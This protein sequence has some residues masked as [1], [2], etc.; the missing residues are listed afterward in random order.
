[1][2]LIT[3][4]ICPECGARVKRLGSKGMCRRCEVALA[5]Q[6]EKQVLLELEHGEGDADGD[7]RKE[8]A[9]LRRKAER[10]LRGARD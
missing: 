6:V 3:Y 10:T 8:L 7:A 9:A 5:I 1:V 4:E 2:S